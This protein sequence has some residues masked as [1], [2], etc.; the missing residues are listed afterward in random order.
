[1]ATSKQLGAYLAGALAS[2]AGLFAVFC[3]VGWWAGMADHKPTPNNWGSSPSVFELYLWP[4]VHSA[5]I[6]LALFGV[7]AWIVARRLS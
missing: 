7:V 2:L 4:H 3:A 5:A 6:C 1:M